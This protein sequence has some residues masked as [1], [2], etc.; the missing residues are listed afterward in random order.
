VF[1][2]RVFRR[3]FEPKK[4]GVTGGWR[5]VHNKEHHDLYSLPSIIKIIKSRRKRWV[6]H[7]A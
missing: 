3:I 5:K 7:V 1:E 6:G 4:G 2:N